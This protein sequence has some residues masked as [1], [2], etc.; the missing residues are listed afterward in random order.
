MS[1]ANPITKGC[2]MRHDR[3]AFGD[4]H[5]TCCTFHGHG[6]AWEEKCSAKMP[7]E[8]TRPTIAAR[9]LTAEEV[10]ADAAKW[11]GRTALHISHEAI[12][13][14][15]AELEADSAEAQRR[16]ADAGKGDI[17]D[18]AWNTMRREWAMARENYEARA[19]AI[20]GSSGVWPANFRAQ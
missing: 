14:R 19:L 9:I 17:T 12:R 3:G 8:K 5:G 1:D 16:L 18:R 2:C 7:P 11:G 15:V 6:G 20:S 10:G 4:W 13:A